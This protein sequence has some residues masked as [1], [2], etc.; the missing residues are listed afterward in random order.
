MKFSARNRLDL[1]AGYNKTEDVRDTTNLTENDKYHTY[2]IGGVYGLGSEAA[3]I[4]FDLGANQEWRRYDNSG[5]LNQDRERDTQSLSAIAYYRVA[6]KTKAL[7]ELRHHDY[8]YVL[9]TSQLNS[10]SMVYLTGLIWEATAQTTGTAKFGY[11]KKD[12][13]SSAID[14]HSNGVWEVGIDWQPLT[15]STFS[16]SA[17]RG[18]DEGSVTEDFIEATNTSLNWNH[19]WRYNLSSDG[20]YSYTEEDYSNVNQR[21]DKTSDIGFNVNYD[22]RRWLTLGVGYT[23][24]DRD[25]NVSV[26]GFEH[27]IFMFSGTISL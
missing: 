15:Y 13:D 10:R 9:S 20:Y 27:S 4:H 26:R 6:P 18:T 14:S 5:A 2:N 17:R 19:Q 12:F 11:E 25:S 24:R 3:V 7:I 22:I 16:L 23:Y 21:T 1:Q 8:D